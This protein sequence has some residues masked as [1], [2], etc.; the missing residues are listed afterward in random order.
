MIIAFYSGS[1]TSMIITWLTFDDT[2]DS[3]VEYGI[4]KLD[5]V[6]EFL[7][8]FSFPETT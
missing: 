7:L 6:G 3:V 2:L 1:P 5:K 4:D 8:Y